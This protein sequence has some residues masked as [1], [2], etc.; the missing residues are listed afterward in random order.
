MAAE[1]SAKDE[2][3]L[4]NAVRTM[5]QQQQTAQPPLGEDEIPF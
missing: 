5:Q 2:A 1:Y 3:F 4:K